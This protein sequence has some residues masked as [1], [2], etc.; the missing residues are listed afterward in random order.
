[1]NASGSRA[2][3]EINLDEFERR[4]RAAGTQQAG[5]EDPLSELARLVEL[6]Q[7]GADEIFVLPGRFRPRAARWGNA[8]AAR[9]RPVAVVDR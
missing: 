8:A 5:V 4:L 7:A 9:N 2:A 3:A 6:S 1:M